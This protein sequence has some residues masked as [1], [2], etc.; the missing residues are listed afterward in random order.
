[1]L[2]FPQEILFIIFDNADVDTQLQLRQTARLFYQFPITRPVKVIVCNLTQLRQ[3]S[4]GFKN[5]HLVFDFNFSEQLQP[6]DIP[7]SVTHLTF[8]RASNMPLQR[9]IIPNSVTHLEFIHHFNQVEKLGFIPN[10]VTH[11]TFGACFDQ[12]L[13]R[14]DIPDS[15]THLKFT[16]VTQALASSI[17]PNSVTHLT[18]DHD[19]G[20]QLKR[21][22][23]PNSFT[24]LALGIGFRSILNLSTFPNPPKVIE[25][26]A[27]QYQFIPEFWKR[28]VRIIE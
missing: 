15:V 9:G 10:S 1:M 7:N 27:K 17:I 22:V 25:I 14:G 19:R 21:I 26:R 18:L 2:Q 28:A 23:I 4:K 8:N 5:V 11:L 24:H 13:K 6:G 16:D 12:P 3:I 20:S